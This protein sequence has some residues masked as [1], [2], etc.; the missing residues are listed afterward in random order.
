M[1]RMLEDDNPAKP[2]MFH[3]CGHAFADQFRK[4]G[5]ARAL[6][7]SVWAF[8]NVMRLISPEH[9]QYGDVLYGVGVSHFERYHLNNQLSELNRAIDVFRIYIDSRPKNHETSKPWLE[10]LD[11]LG[12]S[13]IYRFERCNDPEDSPKAASALQEAIDLSLPGDQHFPGR[14]NNL[15]TLFIARFERTGRSRRH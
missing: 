5:V 2:V 11:E 3:V 8:E 14:L 6:D 4:S 7:Q 10:S 1:I 15:L 9:P 13:Y 12:L